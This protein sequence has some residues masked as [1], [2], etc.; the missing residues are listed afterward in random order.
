[1]LKRQGTLFHKYYVIDGLDGIGKT[2][3]IQLLK[4]YFENKKRTVLTTRAIGGPV[5]SEIEQLRNIIFENKFGNEI[6]EDLFELNARL[7]LKWIESSVREYSQKNPHN[8]EIIVIQDRGIMS[9][10]TYSAVK[11]MYRDHTYER[12]KKVLQKSRELRAINIILVPE[13]VDMVLKRISARGVFSNF[14]SKYENIEAQKTVLQ[15]ISYELN[16]KGSRTLISYN[17]YYVV[18][19]EEKDQPIDVHLKILNKLSLIV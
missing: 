3:Q 11:G 10:F 12:Y 18:V 14:H 8:K 9:H 16:R 15:K 2:T 17:K 4:T 7:N 1:M 6:E 19:V 5:G 13:S